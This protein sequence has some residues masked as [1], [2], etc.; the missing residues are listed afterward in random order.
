M[1]KLPNIEV[2]RSQDMRVRLDAAPIAA[3]PIDD[4]MDARVQDLQAVGM[5]TGSI[6]FAPNVNAPCHDS[7]LV[8]AQAEVDRLRSGNRKLLDQLAVARQW[9]NAKHGTEYGTNRT[10]PW[11]V[12]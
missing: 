3:R 7:A 12:A 8:I 4:N 10:P 11:E 9:Y 1:D 5:M 2:M 6:T